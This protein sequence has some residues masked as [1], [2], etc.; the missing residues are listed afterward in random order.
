MQIK[1]NLI[2]VERPI[3]Q[4]F[5]TQGLSTLLLRF[6]QKVTFFLIQ[7]LQYRSRERK[8][9]R[10][11]SDI[12]CT[13]F[14]SYFVSLSVFVNYRVFRGEM[15]T[16]FQTRRERVA[17]FFIPSRSRNVHF[18]SRINATFQSR[19]FLALFTFSIRYVS[20]SRPGNPQVYEIYFLRRHIT[21]RIC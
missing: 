19:R 12:L 4:S 3:S 17:T 7:S 5:V 15:S 10:C 2:N 8:C 20:L 14:F 21:W 1:S 13:S 11:V 9:E 18:S 16:L 6:W